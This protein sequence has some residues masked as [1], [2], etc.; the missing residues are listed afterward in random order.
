[1]FKLEKNCC[2][3]F[4]WVKSKRKV[5]YSEE[6]WKQ[7]S[8]Q[9]NLDLEGESV[10]AGKRSLFGTYFENTRWGRE[11]ECEGDRERE[12]ERQRTRKPL[13]FIKKENSVPKKKLHTKNEVNSEYIWAVRANIRSIAALTVPCD[14]Q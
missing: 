14:V 7:E 10:L 11:N 5:L 8:E 6:V 4:A 2:I 9:T 3:I 1:M 13:V 12:I